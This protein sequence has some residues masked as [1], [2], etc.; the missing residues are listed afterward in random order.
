MGLTLSMSQYESILDSNIILRALCASDAPRSTMV[1]SMLR[2]GIHTIA[3]D[4][5]EDFPRHPDIQ[6]I[7]PTKRKG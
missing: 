5:V 1:T 6:V 4:N 2:K 7:N 3:T